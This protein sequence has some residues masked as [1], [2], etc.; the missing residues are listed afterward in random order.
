RWRSLGSVG[1]DT[2]VLRQNDTGPDDVNHHEDGMFIMSGPAAPGS[3]H[4]LE[5]ISIYD[6][7]PTILHAM[8]RPVPSSMRGQVIG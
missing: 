8:G 7:A 5:N 1:H 2:V 3:H 4:N 6:V